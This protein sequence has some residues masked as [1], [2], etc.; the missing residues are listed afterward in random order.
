M[1]KAPP[2]VRA[3]FVDDLHE[4]LDLLP[5]DDIVMVLPHT[6]KWETSNR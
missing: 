1:A 2:G 3:K 5:S 4:T 6:G